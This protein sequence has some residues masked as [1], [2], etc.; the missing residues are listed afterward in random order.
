M[1]ARLQRCEAAGDSDECIRLC[2]A[3]AASRGKAVL[4]YERKDDQM[5]QE[6]VPMQIAG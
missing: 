6:M 4:I 5:A 2:R 3:I 1:L